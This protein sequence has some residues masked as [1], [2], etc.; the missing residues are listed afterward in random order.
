MAQSNPTADSDVRESFRQASFEVSGL[1]G[2]SPGF[3]VRKNG[4]AQ[5]IT[6]DTAG[7]WILAGPALFKVHNLDCRLEDQGYQK[8][9]LFEDQ[10]F[11]VR[12]RDLRVLHDFDKQVRS[13]LGLR[14]LYHESLGTT[15]TRSAYDRLMGRPD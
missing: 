15:C 10:R 14:S 1:D 6:M 9:W 7:R 3:V 2:S 5:T 4:C 8:F 13:I 12:G 11:P